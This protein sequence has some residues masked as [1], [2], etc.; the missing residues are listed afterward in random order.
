MSIG[1]ETIHCACEVLALSMPTLYIRDVPEVLSETLKVR[2][3]Q[4]GQSLSA[5]VVS[6]LQKS[7]AQLSGREIG[8]RLRELNR[9]ES[10][11][12]SEILEAL[13]EGRQ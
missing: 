6:E 10:A 4:Q 8:R 11:S 9:R 13:S 12:V 7:A 5:Y 3:R 2:A 1:S